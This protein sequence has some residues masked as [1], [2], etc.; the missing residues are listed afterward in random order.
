MA[1]EGCDEGR[2][3][4]HYGIGGKEEPKDG[5][6]SAAA[7]NAAAVHGIVNPNL[8]DSITTPEAMAK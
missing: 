5:W 6:V 1:D 7:A 3:G 4:I 8:I 2:S